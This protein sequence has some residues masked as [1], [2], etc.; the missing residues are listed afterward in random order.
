MPRI[1]TLAIIG[2]GLI[3][4]ATGVGA[5]DLATAGFAGANIGT[6]VAWAILLGAFMK[7]VLT[8]GLARWQLATGSTILDGAVTRL[9][10]VVS[11]P[12]AIYFFVWSYVT[13]AAL[14]SGAGITAHA[15]IEPL[16]L[17]E[18]AADAKF[19]LGALHSI[20]AVVLVWMGGFRVF[21][22][23]MAALVV[24]MFASVIVT[25][26]LRQPDLGALLGGL[27]V[28][29]IPQVDD[30]GLAWT[31]ALIG[32]VG[33][34]L[35]IICYGYWIREE[36]R[37][38][39]EHL[40]TCRIDLAVGY[41]ATALFGVSMLVIAQGTGASGRGANLIIGLA[42]ELE[43]TL[44]STGR[45]AFVIGAYAAVI[46]SLLGV[47][48]SVPYVF[49]EFVGVHRKSQD[50][51]AA[52]D[53]KGLPYRAFL[54]GLAVIPLVQVRL[55]FERVQLIYAVLGACFVPLLALVILVLCG[56][57]DWIGRK[58]RNHPVTMLVLIATI[59]FFAYAGYLK[60]AA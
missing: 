27:T 33:G 16:G 50:A 19:V 24:V 2:P 17:F 9:G 57:P 21:E 5:G 14:I 6:A 10:K 59:A 11:I 18:S 30:G 41:A 4:A 26:I 13:G 52:V 3:V 38:G 47:W 15:V 22:R 53:T 36:G 35:T 31:I 29:R 32:G 45:W 54:V 46:S 39:L 20:A 37:V 23:V 42:D 8:E 56:R 34:T 12:F 25:A 43:R 58:A 48:Q 1:R 40:R 55:P 51:G 28:P 7:Y 49:A 44:G 60:L